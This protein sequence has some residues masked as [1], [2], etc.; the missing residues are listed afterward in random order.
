MPA[1][2][3]AVRFDYSFDPIRFGRVDIARQFV[4]E[5]S[6][7]YELD[8]E[9]IDGV[10]EVVAIR[11]PRGLRSARLP[12][13]RLL[14]QAVPLASNPVGDKQLR[15]MRQSDID[16]ASADYRS[17]RSGLGDDH[18]QQVAEVAREA[19]ANKR[20]TDV[21]VMNA[22]YGCGSLATARTWIRRARDRGF[23]C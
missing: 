17:A 14:Q 21:E 8:I 11:H 6:G 7:G 16:R 13:A 1:K 23:D 18:Y 9:I 4:A 10:A 3:T 19:R 20:A 5:I 2:V 12:L 22:F 15:A